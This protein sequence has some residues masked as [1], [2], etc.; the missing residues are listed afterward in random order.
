MF[1]L[2]LLLPATFLHVQQ[3]ELSECTCPEVTNVQ[4]TGQTSSSISFS[5]L[6]AE[7]ATQYKV[8]YVRQ[9]D[10]FV[11]GTTFTSATAH[12]FTGLTPGAYVFYFQTI[13]GGEASGFIGVE[14]TIEQ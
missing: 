14:D 4:K 13:C 3:T 10:G 9:A 11:G 5:W 6:A 1:F 12:V 7:G 8:W 2:W